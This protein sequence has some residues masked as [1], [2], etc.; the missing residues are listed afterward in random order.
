MTGTEKPAA[1]LDLGEAARRA[2]NTVRAGTIAELDLARARARVDYGP[3]GSRVLTG[4]LPWMSSAAGEDRD[5]RPPSV[6]EQVLLLAPAGELSAAWILPGAYAADFPAPWSAG[7]KRVTAYRDGAIVSYDTEAHELEAILP[8]GG[9]ALIAAPGG[10]S[11]T[12][13]TE[14]G[15]DVSIDGNLSVTGTIKAGKAISSEADVSDGSG[16]MK[17]IRTVYN[18]HTHGVPPGPVTPPPNQRMT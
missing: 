3:A 18:P 7:S 15:G 10:L 17:E 5:W 9:K 4:W 6:G 2:F 1:A 11:V 12:G 13:D 14:V 16:S 8:E